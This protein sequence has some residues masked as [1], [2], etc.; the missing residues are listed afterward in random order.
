MTKNIISTNKAPA[1]IGTYSQAVKV[2]N[3]VYMS[4]QI[5]ITAETMALVSNDFHEQITQVFKNLAVIADEAGGTL[6]DAVKLTI[7]L[8]NLDNFTIVNE[9]M[10][11]FFQEPFPS[12]AT[13]GISELPKGA[14]VE[15]DAILHLES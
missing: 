11:E 15:V 2:D 7:Y 4:G 12:R 3:V 5:P 6:N 1:A 10:H 14:Q 8:T 9:V 13:V